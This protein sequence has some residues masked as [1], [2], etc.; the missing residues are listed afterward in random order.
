M[1]FCENCGRE[2]SD[3]AIM[4]PNCGHP[5][6]A[7]GVMTVGQTT[8]YAEWWQRVV[9]YIVDGIIVFVPAWIIMLIASV[10]IARN[11]TVTTDQ[12]GNT[13]INSGAFGRI[14]VAF[15]IILLVGILYRVLLEGGQR[16]QT[17]G[18]MAMKIAVKDAETGGSIGYGRAFVRW[19]VASILWIAFYLPGILDLLFPLWD[20]KKQTLHD[21]AVRSVVLQVQ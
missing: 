21:K 8:A 1:A 3:Q 16:G 4:C 18:K 19:I 11:S 6:N 20:P 17:V 13:T 12:F 14:F 5:R 2:L 15:G 10:G 9:A 7:A